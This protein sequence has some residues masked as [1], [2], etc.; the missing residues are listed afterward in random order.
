MN[1]GD[2]LEVNW[3]TVQCT[4]LYCTVLYCTALYPLVLTFMVLYCTVLYCTILHYTVMNCTVLQCTKPRQCQKA[5]D[6]LLSFS[7]TP[8]ILPYSSL[9]HVCSCAYDFSYSC[10]YSSFYSCI[11]TFPIPA[12]TPLLYLHMYI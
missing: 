2:L 1:L 10:S 6:F 4:V 5:R 9:Q 11:S 12:L 8:L 3:F 7:S